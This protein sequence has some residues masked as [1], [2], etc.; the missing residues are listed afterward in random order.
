MADLPKLS[1]PDR[2][3]AEHAV[4][5]DPPIYNVWR[6]QEKTGGSEHFGIWSPP[7]EIFLMQLAHNERSGTS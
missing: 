5:F 6:Q 1:K 7:P 2:A 3:A 4:D